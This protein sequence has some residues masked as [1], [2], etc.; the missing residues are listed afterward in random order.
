MPL[1]IFFLIVFDQ[2]TKNINQ[3][4]YIESHYWIKHNSEYIDVVPE[5]DTTS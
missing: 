4:S 1:S 2:E 3:Y 5:T